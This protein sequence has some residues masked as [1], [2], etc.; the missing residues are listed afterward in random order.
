MQQEMPYRS[1]LKNTGTFLYLSSGGVHTELLAIISIIEQ[2]KSG[3][4]EY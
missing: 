1:G 3:K 4:M 2:A